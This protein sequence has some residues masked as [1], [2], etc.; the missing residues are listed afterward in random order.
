M[1]LHTYEKCF[2]P[3]SN[4]CGI[5]RSILFRGPTSSLA[6]RSISDSTTICHN[7][8]PLALA[9]YVVSL[10]ILKH[11]RYEVVFTLLLRMFYFF[12]QRMCSQIRMLDV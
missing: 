11:V 6:H 7:L 12:L 9:H 5:S 3:L 4:Q 1:F 2:I 8:T 10:T